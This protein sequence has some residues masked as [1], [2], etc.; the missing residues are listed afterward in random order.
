MCG[1]VSP[2]KGPRTSHAIPGSEESPRTLVAP[3]SRSQRGYVRRSP[4]MAGTRTRARRPP[5]RTR[6]L[7]E[8]FSGISECRNA[9]LR[10]AQMRHSDI[11]ECGTSE[12]RFPACVLLHRVLQRVLHRVSTGARGGDG[13]ATGGRRERPECAGGRAVGGVL[14][15]RR[16][17]TGRAW[18]PAPLGRMHHP[19]VRSSA[20]GVQR[21]EEE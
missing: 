21:D 2:E 6:P 8:P 4:E 15:V 1:S 9:A 7:D 3:P 16:P 14:R 11:P 17:T 18:G 12:C 20:F 5:R 13:E 10:N 19:A